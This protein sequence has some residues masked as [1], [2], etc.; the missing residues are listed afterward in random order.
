MNKERRK[1]LAAV[2]EKLQE[3]KSQL[4]ILTEEEQGYFDN[5]PESFQE[6]EK[7]SIVEDCISSMGDASG[8]IDSVIST[9]E[10]VIGR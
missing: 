7:G 6:G 5:M 2:V 4:D 1:L 8:E 3:A 10:E 9:I